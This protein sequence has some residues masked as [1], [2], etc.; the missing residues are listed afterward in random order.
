VRFLNDGPDLGLDNSALVHADLD[1]VADGVVLL[2]CFPLAGHLR[3]SLSC[4]FLR[5]PYQIKFFAKLRIGSA[6]MQAIQLAN[7]DVDGLR[8]RLRKMSDKELRKFIV[9]PIAD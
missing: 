1:A 6:V 3:R 4:P 5:S 8:T 7:L 2:G 9:A